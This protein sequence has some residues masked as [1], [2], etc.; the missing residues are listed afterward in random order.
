MSQFYTTGDLTYLDKIHYPEITIKENSFTFITGKSG[1]GKSSYLKM[2]NRSIATR[3][4]TVFFQERPLSDYDILSYRRQVLL[5]PQN[6]YL[7]N[8]TVADNFRFYYENREQEL[9]TEEE[10]RKYLSICCM[11]TDVNASCETMSGGE[12][13][14]VFLAIFLSLAADALLL[15]E[16]TAALDEKTADLLM[17][18]LKDYSRRQKLTVVCVCHSRQL[19]DRYADAVI[20]MGGPSDESDH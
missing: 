11:D 6:V 1:C 16:P 7:E 10:I 19:V 9:L 8:G 14:R 12:R 2:L 4:N 3:E 5:V 20:D 17:K 18:N 15:D 13:Q